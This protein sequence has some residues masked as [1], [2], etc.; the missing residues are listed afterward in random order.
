LL[1][2]EFNTILI[3]I[4]V[5]F[6][7]SQKNSPKYLLLAKYP[8]NFMYLP[9][10][11]LLFLAISHLEMHTE[12]KEASKSLTIRLNIPFSS[13]VCHVLSF[14]E[15]SFQQH[16]TSPKLWH[17]SVQVIVLLLILHN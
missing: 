12:Q 14:W 7:F 6:N 15:I 17:W 11:L 9:F 3:F 16:S 4:L 1:A 10:T 2:D 5:F 8:D 13:C